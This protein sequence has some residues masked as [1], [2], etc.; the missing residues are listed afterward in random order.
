M[1]SSNTFTDVRVTQFN[2][3]HVGTHTVLNL[4]VFVTPKLSFSDHNSIVMIVLIIIGEHNI[5]HEH[6]SAHLVC[7]VRILVKNNP[8]VVLFGYF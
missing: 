5:D 7:L 4:D 6:I 8:Y 3:Y 1:R 2:A